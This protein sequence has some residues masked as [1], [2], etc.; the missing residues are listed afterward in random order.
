MFV[1]HESG[2]HKTQHRRHHLTRPG[3]VITTWRL[4]LASRVLSIQTLFYFQFNVVDKLEDV[5]CHAL[6]V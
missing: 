1:F 2:R 5:R 3:A 4:L 6:G